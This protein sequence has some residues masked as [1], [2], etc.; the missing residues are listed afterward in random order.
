MLIICQVKIEKEKIEKE[1]K[2]KISALKTTDPRYPP[3]SRW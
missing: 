2:R 1:R 3:G